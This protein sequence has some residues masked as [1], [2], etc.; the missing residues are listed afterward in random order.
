[1]ELFKMGVQLSRHRSGE[2]AVI[3]EAENGEDFQTYC[4]PDGKILP[5]G[6]PVGVEVYI[7]GEPRF[8]LLEDVYYKT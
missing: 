6:T 7:D 5:A 3:I 8:F 4:D 1:M 2:T